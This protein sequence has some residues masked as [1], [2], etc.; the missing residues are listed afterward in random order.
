MVSNVWQYKAQ[1]YAHPCY[2]DGRLEG[3]SIDVNIYFMMFFALLHH[4]IMTYEVNGSLIVCEKF[5]TKVAKTHRHLWQ[6]ALLCLHIEPYVSR[7]QALIHLD[8]YL[9]DWY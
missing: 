8:K 6:D 4:G 1:Y 3:D 7:A 5:P 2:L 9:I